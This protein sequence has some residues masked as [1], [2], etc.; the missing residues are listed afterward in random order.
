MFFFKKQIPDDSDVQSLHA[1]ARAIAKS[2]GHDY[3]GVEHLF[4]SFRTLP[5]EHF[6]WAVLRAFDI[7]LDAFFA[8]LE[9]KA[10]VSIGRVAPSSLPV[11]PRLHNILRAAARIARRER[12]S[13]V[14]PLH[15]LAAIAHERASLPAVLL[16]TAY[17]QAH[18]E[19]RYDRIL[20]DTLLHRLLFP[21]QKEPL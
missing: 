11:T 6:I 20:A 16:A 12:A 17:Q 19:I 15:L 8:E 4:L 7:N 9:S 14:T 2:F 18:A 1:G 13:H 3:V 5:S 21:G 10:R